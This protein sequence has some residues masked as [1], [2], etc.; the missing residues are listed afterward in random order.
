[1]G[2]QKDKPE[3]S[4]LGNSKDC[5]RFGTWNVRTLT[6][7]ELE[8]IAEMKRYRLDVL[9]VSE[10]KMR[11]NGMKT[12]EGV[13]CVYS[14]VQEG[15]AKAGVAIYMAEELAVHIKEWKCISERLVLVRLKIRE[16]WICF[17]QVYAPT[18][19]WPW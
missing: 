12:V 11:G 15:R 8:L 1:M 10:G 16:E 17:V 6:G 3:D 9:G 2:P 5:Y 13:T 14:G 18:E 4:K 19:V 7:K